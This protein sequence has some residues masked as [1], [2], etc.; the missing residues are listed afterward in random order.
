MCTT[1]ACVEG[2]SRVCVCSCGCVHLCLRVCV[3]V[4]MHVTVRGQHW[5]VV[6]LNF[7]HLIFLRYELLN[8]EF[9]ESVSLSV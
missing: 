7:H 5:V 8:L 3:K 9:T 6:F 2:G 1:C 4:S